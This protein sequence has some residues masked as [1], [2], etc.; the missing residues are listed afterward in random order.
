MK[1][2]FI[3]FTIFLLSFS[4][5]VFAEED[6]DTPLGLRERIRDKAQDIN[7]DSQRIA[8]AKLVDVKL[9]D[10]KRIVKRRITN[11]QEARQK[12]VTARERYIT[13]KENYRDKKQELNKLK[14]KY[15]EC[16]DLDTEDCKQHK[17]QTKRIAIEHLT[18]SADLILEK[19]LELKDRI[20]A[21]TDLTEEEVQESI[22]KIDEKIVEIE[23]AKA[24]LANINED[25]SREEIKEAANTIKD[26]WKKV[27]VNMYQVKLKHL[28]ARFRNLI[29][30][31]EI[32]GTRAQ[33]RASEVDSEI[34]SSLLETYNNKIEEA[35]ENYQLGKAEWEKESTPREIDELVKKA[36]RYLRE[37]NENLKEARKI[38]K[39]I[40][41]E[42]R[43]ND[44]D[45]SFEIEEEEDNETD[46]EGGDEE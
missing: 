35:K 44:K 41:N 39:D 18:H 36:H 33:E 23:I 30:K 29:A 9:V 10:A 31:A 4:T 3:I 46:N 14:T 26:A 16:L 1:K 37:T 19:F 8:D 42:L 27:K 11:I 7:V 17:K 15:Q 20:E 21:S 22:T 13:A 45:I 32:L 43:E 28:G 6:T 34:L 5:V 2:L 24:T 38:L 40:R 25:T 12:V